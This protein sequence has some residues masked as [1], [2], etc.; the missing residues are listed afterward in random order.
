MTGCCD[1]QGQGVKG[2]GHMGGWCH[3][4]DTAGCLLYGGGDHVVSSDNTVSIFRIS[5][6]TL[7]QDKH[8]GL[9]VSC[10]HQV[11]PT[12]RVTLHEPVFTP[13]LR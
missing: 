7:I 8:K 2:G 12:S 13:K 4:R 11:T 3:L 6:S 1:H 9:T 5:H 10:V